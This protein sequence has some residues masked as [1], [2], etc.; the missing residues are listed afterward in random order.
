MMDD[1]SGIAADLRGEKPVIGMMINGVI[2]P[3]GNSNRTIDM[4]QGDVEFILAKQQEPV[5]MPPIVKLGK[6][7]PKKRNLRKERPPQP[8]MVVALSSAQQS[9]RLNNS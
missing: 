3:E 6:D 7:K 1:N 4:I 9:K 5:K 2:Q 8:A